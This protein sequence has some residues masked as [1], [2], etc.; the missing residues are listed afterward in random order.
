MS[1]LRQ[2]Q[3]AL[4]HLHLFAGKDECCGLA[5]C[6]FRGSPLALLV[7]TYEGV[8]VKSTSS[9]ALLQQRLFS[10]FQTGTAALRVWDA[11]VVLLASFFPEQTADKCL[12][13]AV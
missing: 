7:S 2:V 3:P 10:G 11:L 5:T 9:A 13:V 8:P 12:A 4:L 1:C 6:V